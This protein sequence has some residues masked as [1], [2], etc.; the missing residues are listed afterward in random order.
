MT[1][2]VLPLTTQVAQSSRKTRGNRILAAQ[3]GQGF[4]QFAKDGYNSQ[5]DKW[6][7]NFNNLNNTDRGTMNTFYETVGSDV[8][9]TWTATGDATSK[10]WRI[11]KDTFNETP[12]SGALYSITFNITQQFD[13]GT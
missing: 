5:F 13:L 10:K 8:W 9:F 6:Q 2:P 3:F 11:D 1:A 4:G 12:Q 7:L